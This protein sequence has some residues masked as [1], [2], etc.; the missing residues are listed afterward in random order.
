MIIREQEY[1]RGGREKKERRVDSKEHK[2]YS[3]EVLSRAFFAHP[4]A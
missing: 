2:T 4:R 3:T 1:R